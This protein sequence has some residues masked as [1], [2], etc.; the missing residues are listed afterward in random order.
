M[1]ATKTNSTLT[2]H[3]NTAADM[4]ASNP[5][6][7]SADASIHDAIVLFTKKGISAAPVINGAGR[8]VGVISHSDVIIHDRTRAERK[9]PP[10]NGDADNSF[11][12]PAGSGSNS[13][14]VDTT[15]VGSLMTPVVF[16]VSPSTPARSV[17]QEMLSLNVHRLFVV[18]S[19]GALVGV[20]SPL[21]VLRNLK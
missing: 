6:S 8:P 20:I 10:T 1:I 12:D 18:D 5:V 13:I 14:D 16:A 15:R 21:D 7:L 3:A 9:T 11:V 2:L 4:M 19:E 17:V